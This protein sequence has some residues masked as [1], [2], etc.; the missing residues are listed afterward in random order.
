MGET[1]ANTR[2]EVAF[3]SEGD[4][5]F[6]GVVFGSHP[7]L[8]RIVGVTTTKGLGGASGTFQITMKK[9]TDQNQSWAQLFPAP[10]GV[11]VRITYIIDGERRPLLWGMIDSIVEN[12][13]RQGSGARTETYTITGRDIGKVFEDTK[14]IVNLFA[15]SSIEMFAA[16][17]QAYNTQ[18]ALGPPDVVIRD[19]LKRWLGNNGLASRQYRL[20]QS[21]A[22]IAGVENFYDALNLD[23]IQKMDRGHGETLDMSILNPDQ[24]GGAALWDI[25]QQYCNGLINEMWLD[26]A[27]DQN[28]KA[29]RPAFY[30]RERIF[31]TEGVGGLTLWDNAP[32]FDLK[33]GMVRGWQLAKGGAA[34]RYNYWLL[35]GGVLG[36]QYSTQALTHSI[37]KEP[38]KPGAIP[39]INLDSMQ[40]HGIRPYVVTTNFLPLYKREKDENGELK[41]IGQNFITLAANWL[42]RAHDWYGVAPGQLSGT[43]TTTRLL[44]GLR[45]GERVREE[46]HNGSRVVYYI[47]SVT[48][49][50]SYPGAGTSTI[51]VTHGQ[52]DGENLLDALYAQYE[53]RSTT[54]KALSDVKQSDDPQPIEAQTRAPQDEVIPARSEDEK[55]ARTKTGAPK[56][57]PTVGNPLTAQAL[58]V[59]LGESQ[60]PLPPKEAPAQPDLSLSEDDLNRGTKISTPENT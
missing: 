9:P 26:L 52:I 41:E 6:D 7:Q 16:M 13:Q 5:N 31:R 25:L 58:Q 22:K 18:P 14:T 15:V 37:G 60:D 23:T 51:T 57:V 59:A 56:S 1:Y 35:H 10:E 54:S 21:L 49:N 50:W 28:K 38:Y 32:I 30:L 12:V 3:H 55:A 42:K 2:C 40:R 20:P 19:I 24:Q 11:W 47:E 17:L 33:L 53:E 34:N 39:I 4:D 46:R 8:G 48:H 44:P 29:W 36:D 43:I 27:Y 45:V